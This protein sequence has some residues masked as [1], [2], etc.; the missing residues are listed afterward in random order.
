MSDTMIE[1]TVKEGTEQK[2]TLVEED[3]GDKTYRVTATFRVSL[4]KKVADEAHYEIA[5]EFGVDATF[6]EENTSATV[7]VSHSLH[8]I[9]NTTRGLGQLFGKVCGLN[10]YTRTRL[11]GTTVTVEFDAN[12][13]ET[14]VGATN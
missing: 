7:E 8:H 3:L 13:H 14:V 2:L 10:R 6:N 4:D 11:D 1:D 5:W 9:D 12:M